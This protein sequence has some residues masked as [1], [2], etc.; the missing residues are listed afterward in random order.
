MS[1][2]RRREDNE[3]RDCISLKECI[4]VHSGKEAGD[5][6]GRVI[7]T[8]LRARNR[9][10]G[11][12]MKQINIVGAHLSAHRC[13]RSQNKPFSISFNACEWNRSM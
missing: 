11:I 1:E 4:A 6:E 10:V 12:S 7:I 3:L 9:G 2:T 5:C 13:R 8:G